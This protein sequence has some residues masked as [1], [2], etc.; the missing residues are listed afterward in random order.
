M[1]LEFKRL[2]RRVRK[3]N[4]KAAKWLMKEAMTNKSISP[5]GYLPCVMYWSDTPQGHDFWRKIE[6]EIFSKREGGK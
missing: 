3:I 4:R 5:H 2:I 6:D 1:K